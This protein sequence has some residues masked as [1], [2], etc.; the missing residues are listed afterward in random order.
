MPVLA[1]CIT[2]SGFQA[3]PVLT[4]VAGA[5]VENL[6]EGELRCF[7]SEF[8]TQPEW[9]ATAA[10]L[11]FNS[12][13]Q[14]LLS[15]TGIIPFRFPTVL[16]DQSELRDY[17]REH[18]EQYRE[19]LHRLKDD[20]Q[21]EVQVTLK[22]SRAE[23]QTTTSGREYLQQR[24]T[25][26][27]TLEQTAAKL[28]ELTAGLTRDWLQKANSQGLRCYALVKRS[29][30]GDLQRIVSEFTGPAEVKVRVT[31]PWAATEFM[32]LP[33]PGQPTQP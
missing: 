21:M 10:V 29:S 16:G 20:V 14:H 5:P 6:T 3:V 23:D 11:K 12:V 27:Q 17:I 28:Q 24:Q 30:V 18:S 26:S 32:S 13:L 9:N 15:R 1:Y 22:S 2:E 19:A 25:R 7:I 4:G 31:G 8:R 33:A